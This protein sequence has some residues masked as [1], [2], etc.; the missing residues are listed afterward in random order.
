MSERERTPM[1]RRLPGSTSFLPVLVLAAMICSPAAKAALPPPVQVFYLPL[2]EDQV[3]SALRSI[4][5][6]KEACQSMHSYEVQSPV[7]TYVS[8]AVIADGTLLVYDH[9]EDG[10]ETDIR[11]PLQP[12]TEVWGDGD[13][14]N[15]APPGIPSDTLA[16]GDVIVL[17]NSV[18]TASR[19]GVVD[20]DGG[21]RMAA[22]KTVA[23]TRAAW[24]AGTSTFLAG[25]VEVYD[26]NSWGTLYISPVGE[27]LPE[28]MFGYSALVIMA[29]AE[30]TDLSIDADADG[31]FED[32]ATLGRGESYLVEGGVNAGGRVV[33]SQPVQAALVTGRR[34]VYESRWF[35]LFPRERWSSDYY[36]PVG[37]V[38]S[39]PTRIFLHNPAAEQLTVRWESLAGPGPDVPLSPGGTSSVEM[40]EDSGARFHSSSGAPFLALAAADSG[41]SFHD[42]GFALIPGEELTPQVLVGWG[43]GRDPLSVMNPGENGSPVWVTAALPEGGTA[44]QVCVDFNGDG[45]G[46]LYDDVVTIPPF[47]S[48]KIYDPDGDQTG[49]ALA[50]CDESGASLAAAWGQDPDVAS[51]GEPAI[52][53][54]TTIPPFPSFAAGKGVELSADLSGDGL[55]GPGDGLRYS[56]VVQNSSALPVPDVHLYDWVPLHTTYIPGSTFLDDGSAVTAVPDE[57]TTPFPLDEGGL[58]IGVLHFEG[59]VTVSFEVL[60]GEDPPPGADRIVNEA[61]VSALGEERRPRT[62]T[63][64]AGRSGQEEGAGS[65]GFWKNHPASWPV[66]TLTVGGVSYSKALALDLMAWKGSGDKTYDFFRQLAAARLNVLSGAEGGCVTGTMALADGWMALHPPGSGVSGWS[67]EW[68][69]ALPWK[70]RLDSYNNGLLCAYSREE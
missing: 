4:F 39:R 56:V 31:I 25:A 37:S 32:S 15:G 33:S 26:T 57:G 70:E 30:G 67:S 47:G 64:L 1:W 43:P 68:A 35:T 6:G 2:P 38:G 60:I 63:H 65:Q 45:G 17:D 62:E 28:G 24:A 50:V 3:L 22:A 44:A 58:D 29:A 55:P 23:V 42:W 16:A 36:T 51:W 53:V 5:P 8:I 21:D 27:N 12:S 19:E 46:I 52:D 40:P 69:E 66:G 14:E 34:C 54:G 10:F 41:S 20:F 48:M 11:S 61:L 18:D 59:N 13:P 49:M 7:T 9:W